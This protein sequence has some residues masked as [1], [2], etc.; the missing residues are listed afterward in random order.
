MGISQS[1]PEQ[2]LNHATVIMY[3]T[4][5][6][7][8]CIRARQLFQSKQVNFEEIDVGNNPDLWQIMQERSGRATVPQIF[9]DGLHIGGY[10]DMAALNRAGKLNQLLFNSISS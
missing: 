5:S 8:Y 6:C 4:R 9:I 2:T 7:P 3:A 10:D 1:T